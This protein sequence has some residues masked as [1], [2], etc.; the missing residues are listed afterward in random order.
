MSKNGGVSRIEAEARANS[1]RHRSK[2]ADFPLG[3]VKPM[4]LEERLRQLPSAPTSGANIRSLTY[5]VFGCTERWEVIGAGKS[6]IARALRSDPCDSQ[7]HGE[8]V[9]RAAS[10]PQEAASNNGHLRPVP[11]SGSQRDRGIEVGHERM[12]HSSITTTMCIY[13]KAMPRI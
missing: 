6:P 11:R 9:L 1:P 13:G 7:L 3:K 4:A 8:R 2:W 10:I 5:S 12:G